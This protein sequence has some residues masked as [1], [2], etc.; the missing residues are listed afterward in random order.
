MCLQIYWPS[1][2]TFIYSVPS[3]FNIALIGKQKRGSSLSQVLL[4]LPGDS[5]LNCEDQV[6]WGPM[7]PLFI[8]VHPMRKWNEMNPNTTV[9]T[10]IVLTWTLCN[11]QLNKLIVQRMLQSQWRIFFFSDSAALAYKFFIDQFLE[12]GLKKDRCSTASANILLDDRWSKLNGLFMICNP[13]EVPVIPYDAFTA[14]TCKMS[15]CCNRIVSTLDRIPGALDGKEWPSLKETYT[16]SIMIKQP[17]KDCL[18]C[19]TN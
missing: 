14:L 4:Y 3:S 2:W 8:G 16:T 12:D 13:K 7:L 5:P 17:P 15:Y 1:F 10:C 9:Y 18:T 19:V 11:G 6:E